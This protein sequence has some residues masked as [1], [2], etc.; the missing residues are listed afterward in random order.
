MFV[1]NFIYPHLTGLPL[2]A[3]S[4]THALTGPLAHS[5]GCYLCNSGVSFLLFPC[6][7][8]LLRS[9]RASKK[10]MPLN[11]KKSH[12]K[13]KEKKDCHVHHRLNQD[14]RLFWVSCPPLPSLTSWVGCCQPGGNVAAAPASTRSSDTLL[15][16]RQLMTAASWFSPFFAFWG[17]TKTGG[18]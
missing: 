2:S 16:R 10:I 14:C 18:I 8:F 4:L 3:R 13:T 5:I 9:S 17:Y 15:N 7:R 6:L 1:K 11:K 12:R